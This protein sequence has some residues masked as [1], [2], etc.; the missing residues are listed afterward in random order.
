M[1]APGVIKASSWTGREAR[2]LREAMRLSQREYAAFL[3]AASRTV[4]YWEAQGEDVVP[5]SEW[6]AALDT[7]LAQASPHVQQRFSALKEES[8][9][10]VSSDAPVAP[11]TDVAWRDLPAD[12]GEGHASLVQRLDRVPAS[13]TDITVIRGMLGS[14][15][16]T[17]HQFG[18]GFARRAAIGFL[19][20]VV[21]PRLGAPGPDSVRS[22]LHAVA[23]EFYMRIA[24]MHLDVADQ[25]GAR[26]AAREAF[27][28]AQVSEDLA[29]CSWVM[30]MSALLETW[31]GNA[32]AAVGYARAGVGLA[33]G[34]P[35]LV[36]AFAQG[37]LARALATT[38]D[39]SG[40]R[41][42]MASARSM[43][44]SASSTE[45]VLVPAT[46]RDSYSAAYVLDEEAH[47]HRDLGEDSRALSLSEKSLR[48]RGPDR[49]TRNRA[50]AT[51]N[52]VLSFA[53]LGQIEQACDG[54]VDLLGLV[55]ILDSSRVASRLDAALA[56]LAPYRSARAV[57]ELAEQVRAARIKGVHF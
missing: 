37:K 15:T 43:F 54:A 46:I 11:L 39:A 4:A 17:D 51:G 35:K 9:R 55:T 30:S 22:P 38:G 12:L 27:R 10:K 49:F 48:M 40:T 32:T 18:G 5:R 3:G 2:L 53:R 28:Q 56:A 33:T 6:Q 7:A 1:D 16:A 21:Q 45:D 19:M 57:A 31:L 14:L 8:T 36:Q 50:F 24:W 26:S 29:A 23:A 25:Q 47:C 44:E 13:E 41:D 34:G 20:E 42:A 52:A